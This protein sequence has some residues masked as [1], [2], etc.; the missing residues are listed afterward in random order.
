M[1]ENKRGKRKGNVEP[2]SAG[3]PKDPR[4]EARGEENEMSSTMKEKEKER[5]E[6]GVRKKEKEVRERKKETDRVER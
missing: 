3:I 5:G 4:D 6:E 1:R 2:S